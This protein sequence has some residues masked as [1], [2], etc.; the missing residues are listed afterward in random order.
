VTRGVRPTVARDPET[1]LEEEMESKRESKL[2]EVVEGVL[3]SYEEH[4]VL[5]HLEGGNLPNRD[6]V[7]GIVEDLLQILFPGFLECGIVPRDEV[8]ARTAEK[9]SSIERRMKVEIEKVLRFQK[10]AE[11]SAHERGRRARQVSLAF[12]GQIPAVRDILATDIE[13]AFEGDPAATSHE[14]IVLAYP[15]L[16]AIAVQRMAHVLYLEGI[17]IVPRVMTEYAHAHTGIDIDHGTGV[18]IGETC[19]I[20]NDVKIY[21]GVTLGA[22]SFQKDAEGRV[23]KGTKRHPDIEDR[24]TIYSGATILGDI[25][26]GMGSVIGGNAW[27]MHT[28]PPETR[29]LV[30]PPQQIRLDRAIDDYQI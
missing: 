13:A 22:R 8:T 28:V 3:A 6:A 26:I 23:I 10:N 2:Q 5:R 9:L 24:V 18:V 20:G 12:L 4:G 30:T 29:I 7:W 25:R 14:E 15:G 21:Q 27:L 1:R 11:L 16:Q 17:P 19:T